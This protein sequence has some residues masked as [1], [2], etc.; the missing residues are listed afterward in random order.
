LAEAATTLAEA[1][2]AT[3][4]TEATTL[5]EATTATTLTEATTA[6]TL[7]EATATT[8]VTATRRK[9]NLIKL[10]DLHARRIIL[11]VLGCSLNSPSTLLESTTSAY[12]CLAATRTASCI[13]IKILVSN[14]CLNCII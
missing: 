13:K 4:L 6:A 3:T 10:G 9:W 1:T 7:A 11:C 14:L 2:T 8:H 5:A 12:T